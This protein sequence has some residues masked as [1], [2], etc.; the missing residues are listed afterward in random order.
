MKAKMQT[1]ILLTVISLHAESCH[2]TMEN[3]HHS[4]H[5]IA[6]FDITS[7][8]NA[9]DDYLR[10]TLRLPT[11]AEGLDALMHNPGNLEGWNGPYL[12]KGIPLDPWGRAY[13]YKCPGDHCDWDLYSYGSD[14]VAGGKG[15]DADIESWNESW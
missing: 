13:I 4:K 5:E 11:T 15:E 6:K 3:N 7:L 9:I 10:D 1:A 2:P 8:D 14:G 12:K